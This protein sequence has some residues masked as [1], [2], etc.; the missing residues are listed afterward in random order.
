MHPYAH[1]PTPYE[2]LQEICTNF[3]ETSMFITYEAISW[4]MGLLWS[5]LLSCVLAPVALSGLALD[6]LRH[7]ARKVSIHIR[8][9]MAVV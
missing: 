8:R 7:W 1:Q 5:V 6:Y 3:G 4:V 2:K 9:F